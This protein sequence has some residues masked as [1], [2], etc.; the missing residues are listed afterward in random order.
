M[1]GEVFGLPMPMREESSPEIALGR[2][3]EEQRA[4]DLR[5][6]LE[7]GS[8]GREFQ[9]HCIRMHDPSRA[10]FDSSPGRPISGWPPTAF[11]NRTIWIASHVP[12]PIWDTV[13]LAPRCG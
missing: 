9:D 8:V 2:I 10:T 4:V 12:P 13:R 7:N 3:V 11:T 5:E 1:H 6:A